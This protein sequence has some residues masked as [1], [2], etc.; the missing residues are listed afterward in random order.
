MPGDEAQNLSF[1]RNRLIWNNLN[2]SLYKDAILE[3]I[4]NENQKAFV[5]IHHEIN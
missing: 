1:Y 3:K 2:N 4:N 5:N